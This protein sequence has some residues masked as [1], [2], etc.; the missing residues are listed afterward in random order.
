MPD[1]TITHM[2]GDCDGYLWGM[3]TAGPMA[4]RE[5]PCGPDFFTIPQLERLADGHTSDS[6]SPQGVFARL[7]EA[8][9]GEYCTEHADDRWWQEDLAMC[10]MRCRV[11][12]AEED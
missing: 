7:R 5:D 8:L 1:P 9:I 11:Y 3:T 10:A 2:R 6:G 12:R 4:W